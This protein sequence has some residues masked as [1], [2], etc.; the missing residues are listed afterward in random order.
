MCQALSVSLESF[1]L[2]YPR[3]PA[4]KEAEKWPVPPAANRFFIKKFPREHSRQ[5]GSKKEVCDQSDQGLN[6]GSAI[7]SA[8]VS[9]C[10]SFPP[11]LH[12]PSVHTGISGD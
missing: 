1:R 5:S 12:C 6:T 8:L 7:Y 4:S 9:F 11:S 10:P 3:H 2:K